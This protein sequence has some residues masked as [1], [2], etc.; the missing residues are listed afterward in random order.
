M[1]RGHTRDMM[2]QQWKPVA[3]KKQEFIKFELEMPAAIIS[4]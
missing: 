3:E 4:S 1:E 2:H